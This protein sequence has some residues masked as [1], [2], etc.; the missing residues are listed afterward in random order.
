MVECVPLPL[1]FLTLTQAHSF[2]PVLPICL[3]VL[4]AVVTILCSRTCPM[5]RSPGCSLWSSSLTKTAYEVSSDT[6]Q[7]AVLITDTCSMDTSHPWVIT[8]KGIVGIAGYMTIPHCPVWV[9]LKLCF[10][11]KW[12]QTALLHLPATG[13][14]YHEAL[15]LFIYADFHSWEASTISFSLHTEK[16]TAS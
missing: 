6:Q 16:W 14:K 13:S 5:V 9:R 4:S 3:T 7:D 15:C 10:P 2:S 8:Q 11:Q 1:P 12:S